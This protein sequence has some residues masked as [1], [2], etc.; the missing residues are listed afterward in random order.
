MDSKAKKPYPT[1]EERIS[2]AENK[3]ASL[4]ALIAARKKHIADAEA[5]LEARK[6][7]LAKDEAM[8]A[9]LVSHKD[10]LMAAREKVTRKRTPEEIAEAR[11]ANIAKARESRLEKTAKLANLEKILSEKGITLDEMIEKL[12][13]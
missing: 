6:A 3:I 7:A 10:H 4:Q 5:K 1:R 13:G 2:M 8:L 11:K 9:K 12:K